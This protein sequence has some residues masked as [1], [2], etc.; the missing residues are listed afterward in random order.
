[1]LVVVVS[2]INGQTAAQSKEGEGAKEGEAV[3]EGV[4]EVRW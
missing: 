2:S 4:D 1:M 3:N